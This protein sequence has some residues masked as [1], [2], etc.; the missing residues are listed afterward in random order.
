MITLD[1]APHLTPKRE[2]SRR[3]E[4]KY[5][6]SK[7]DDLR[8]KDLLEGGHIQQIVIVLGSPRGVSPK[9]MANRKISLGT[10]LKKMTKTIWQAVRFFVAASMLAFSIQGFLDITGIEPYHAKRLVQGS[11]ILAGHMILEAFIGKISRLINRAK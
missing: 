7:V 2:I 3:K 9:M 8:I 1:D 5:R 4:R 10:R 6:I 11:T